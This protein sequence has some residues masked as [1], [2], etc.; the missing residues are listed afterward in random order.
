MLDSIIRNFNN[1]NQLILV[2]IYKLMEKEAT[3]WC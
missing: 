1:E 2:S 3:K